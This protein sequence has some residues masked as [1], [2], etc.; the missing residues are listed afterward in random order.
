MVIE[1]IIE[2]CF[3]Y[4]TSFLTS[5]VAVCADNYSDS[6]IKSPGVF[7][8]WLSLSEYAVIKKKKVIKKKHL[9]GKNSA[10]F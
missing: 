10:L 1:V 4:E 8:L 7:L 3:C 2:I 5:F 6:C 9:E